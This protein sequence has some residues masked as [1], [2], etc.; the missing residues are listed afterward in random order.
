MGQYLPNDDRDSKG[1]T[2]NIKEAMYIYVNDPSLNRNLGKSNS[3]TYG[4]RF[5]KTHLHSNSNSSVLPTQMWPK[6]PPYNNVGACTTSFGRY[7]PMWGCLPFHPYCAIYPHIP[8]I[9]NTPKTPL[10]PP[11]S[12]TIFGRHTFLFM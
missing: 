8:L 1:V 10:Q 5:Y 12:G 9:P 7:C 4:T 11:F 6:A 2:R 3:H